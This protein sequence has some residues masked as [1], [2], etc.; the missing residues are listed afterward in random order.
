MIGTTTNAV[1]WVDDGT[2]QMGDD[3]EVERDVAWLAAE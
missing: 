1:A 3:A 2:G